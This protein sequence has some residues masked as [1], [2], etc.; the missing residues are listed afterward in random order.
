M[1]TN[2]LRIYRSRFRFLGTIINYI[3]KQSLPWYK[4]YY[5]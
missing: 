1:K 4:K 5:I 2:P 3:I